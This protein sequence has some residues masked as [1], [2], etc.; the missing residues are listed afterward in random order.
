MASLKEEIEELEGIQ[1]IAKEAVD[2]KAE[3]PVPKDVDG[4]TFKPGSVWFVIADV[5]NS[6]TTG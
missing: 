5:D 4:V 6:V 2:P 1:Y 3:K